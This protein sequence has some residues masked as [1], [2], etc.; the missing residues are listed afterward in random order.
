VILS[1]SVLPQTCSDINYDRT[2]SERC[3]SI[4]ISL[5]DSRWSE[6][7]I[8]T[9]KYNIKYCSSSRSYYNLVRNL[10]VCSLVWLWWVID[11]VR[12]EFESGIVS[13]YFYFIFVSFKESRL[14]VPWCAGGRCGM[15]CSD[16]DRGRSRIHSV[17]DREWSHRSGTRW[18]GHREVEWHR[19]RSAPCT[20]R[21]G[22]RIF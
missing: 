14:I 22:A 9:H 15:T 12:F 13:F 6:N 8:N 11:L 3:S 4:R 7:T 2:T 20:W 19:V 1:T 16:E 10:V 17:G 18:P 21:R 5:S